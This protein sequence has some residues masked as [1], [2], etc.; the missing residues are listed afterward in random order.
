LP[1]APAATKPE[2]APKPVARTPEPKPEPKPAAPSAP[3][4][5][6]AGVGFAVQLGAFSSAADAT[7]LRDRARAAGLSAFV[8][9]VQTDKG[10]L[11]RVQV[12]PVADRAAAEQ[13]KAQVAAKLGISGFVHA[14]P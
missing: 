3:A 5:A 2:P 13:L 8:Q 14:H 6:A 1:E 10:P 9:T 7:A 12:G 4:P 11:T